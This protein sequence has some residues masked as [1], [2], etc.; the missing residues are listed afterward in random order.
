MLTRPLRSAWPSAQPV[1]PSSWGRG[2]LADLDRLAD[3]HG[4]LRRDRLDAQQRLD[5][6][7]RQPAVVEQP[8]R[9]S[10]RR[11]CSAA[12]ASNWRKRFIGC[13]RYSSPSWPSGISL[14]WIAGTVGLRS[15]ARRAKRRSSTVP[16][17]RAPGRGSGV[18]VGGGGAVGAGV[19]Q[20]EVV[21]LAVA[22][23][24]P[25][26]RRQ[27]ACGLA[28]FATPTCPR[29]RPECSV[30][31]LVAGRHAMVKLDRAGR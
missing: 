29:C 1:L 4:E 28:L 16:A 7:N 11:A 18:A 3:A 20:G 26:T 6:A 5:R 25:P 12:L 27:P 19:A 10:R 13:V 21:G 31:A 8:L 17:R 23:E 9:D 24:L 30:P 2:E 14:W 15:E 22:G